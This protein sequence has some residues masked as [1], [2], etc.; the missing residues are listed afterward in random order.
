MKV[1]YFNSS[2]LIKWLIVGLVLILGG[3]AVTDFITSNLAVPTLQ[4]GE[5]IY[6]GDSSKKQVALICNVVWGEEHLP[7]MLATLKEEKAKMTFFIGGQWAEK[8]PDLLKNVAQ[9]GHEIGNH[10]YAHLHPTKVS[11]NKN[12]QEISKTEEIIYDITKVK[13]KLFHPPYREI[14]D[15]VA[16]EVNKIGYK[17]IMSSVDT[18]DWQR[19]AA[20]VIVNRVSSK[21]H[22][23]AIILMHP[24]EPTKKALPQMIKEL[25]SQG[26]EIVTISELLS[27]NTNPE[28]K[29][30]KDI[31]TTES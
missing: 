2:K 27:K 5:P 23:G 8:F 30:D 13:T 24:T 21:V 7:E 15:E 31:G 3:Y 25:K 19:P 1:Y 22:N 14:N 9:Q 20:E 17:T 4:Q 11:L 29:F 12:I 6:Q 26:Y 10:G 28:Q 18:I 16:A